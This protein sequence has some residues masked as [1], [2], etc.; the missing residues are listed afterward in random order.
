MKSQTV[1]YQIRIFFSNIIFFRRNRLHRKKDKIRADIKLKK[2]KLSE[3]RKNDDADTVFAKIENLPVFQQAKTILFY[4][5]THSELPTHKYVLK[6]SADKTILL[7]SIH[8]DGLHLK[9]FISLDNIQNGEKGTNEPKTEIFKGK[10]DL[11]IVPGVAFDESKR[12]LGRGKG[13]YDRFLAARRVITIGVGFDFQIIKKIP[14]RIRDVRMKK[15][16]SPEKTIE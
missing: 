16:I 9:K 2:G 15:I 1:F 11:A 12:R 3:D 6:W 7:P 5:S 13:Y 8:R 10:F 14:S 4:W